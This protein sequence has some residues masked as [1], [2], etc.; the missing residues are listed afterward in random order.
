MPNYQNGKIYKIINNENDDIYIGSTC[1][2]LCERMSGHRCDYNKYLDNNNKYITSYKILQYNTA[3][4]ILIENFPCNSKEELH[5]REAFHI[6]NNICV[7][8]CVPGRTN[9]EYREDNKEYYQK[10]SKEYRE[11]NKEY[12]QKYSKEYREDN[13]EYSKEYRK[14]KY[15]NDEEYREKI[16]EKSK[17]Y[18]KEHHE[19]VVKIKREWY[20]KNKEDI[21]EIRKQ[22]YQLN[23]EEH[24][25]KS[26]AYYEKNKEKIN[27][28]RREKRKLAI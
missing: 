23:K 26:K 13:K 5:A 6:I 21:N 28:K 19:E 25:A 8:R 24:I 9:K 11:D 7:N 27:E 14:E 4:I 12:I 10:Y 2:K 16:K 18:R 15:E 1:Q 17:I 22:K 20:E 3:N